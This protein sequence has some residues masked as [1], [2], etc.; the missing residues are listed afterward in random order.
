MEITLNGSIR[1]KTFIKYLLESSALNLDVRVQRQG[2][3]SDAS[4]FM[5]ARF[6]R[7]AFQNNSRSARLDVAPVGGVD[8]VHLGE[9]VHVGK[10]NI[11]LDD[12]LE[13]G[14]S[15]LKNGRKVLD[16]LVLYLLAF[17]PLVFSS[18]GIH[19]V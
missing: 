10:E 3:D 18:T 14:A 5:L 12:L 4:E 2:L 17:R 13:A 7:L 16:A 15:C 19:T 9:V 11:D 6:Q 1:N 8:L